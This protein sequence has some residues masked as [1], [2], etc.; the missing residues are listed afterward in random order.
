MIHTYLVITFNLCLLPLPLFF[1]KVHTYD[2]KR[3]AAASKRGILGAAQIPLFV[4]KI[5]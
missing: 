1:H 3:A 2:S 4:I 5:S